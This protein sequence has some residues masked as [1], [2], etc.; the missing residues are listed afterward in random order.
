[1]PTD[2]HPGAAG[3]STSTSCACACDGFVTATVNLAV[4]PGRTGRTGAVLVRLSSA[5]G[6]DTAMFC[7][8]YPGLSARKLRS[9]VWSST[10]IEPVLIT[11]ASTLKLFL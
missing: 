9:A 1:M 5:S 7:T 2:A 6:S 4:S 10:L 3:S 8:R 11:F